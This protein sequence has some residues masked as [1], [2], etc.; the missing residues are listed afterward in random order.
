MSAAPSG[1]IRWTGAVGLGLR[2][3][4]AE[5]SKRL[6]NL[7]HWTANTVGLQRSQLLQLLWKARDTEIGREAGFAKLTERADEDL[8]KAYRDAVPVRE[9]Y[10]FQDQLTRMREQGEANVLWPGLVRHFAQTS[11]TT[12][13]DK[14][15]PIT[16]EMFASNR[17][18]A[19]DIFAHLARKDAG[20][21][22]S[23]T[24]LM[25]GKMLFLGGSSAVETNEHGVHTGD[26]SG[27]VTPLITWPLSEIYAPGKDVA[28]IGD[29]P[30]KIERMAEVCID[31]DVRSISGMPSWANVLFQRVIELASE[32][33]RDASKVTDVWPHLSL[34]VHGGVKYTPFIPRVNQLVHGDEAVDF[35]HRLELYP[36]SEGFIALQDTANDP[37]LRLLTDIGNFYEFIPVD[38]VDNDDPP[39][40]TAW[41]VEP[42]VRYVVCMTTCSG[43]WRYLIG[44]VVEF[45]TIPAPAPDA[46]RSHHGPCRLRI[47]GRHRHFIN[48]FG[49]NVIVEHV[50]NAVARAARATGVRVG[51]FTAAPVYPRQ[52]QR[53]GLELAVEVEHGTERLDGFAK[54]FDEAMKA[55]NVDYTTK[56]TDSLGMAP[57][58]ITPLPVGAFHAWMAST[59]KLGGQHK[60]P[61]CANHRDILDAVVA[62]AH[63][64]DPTLGSSPTRST[65]STPKPTPA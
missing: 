50:E 3:K 29:W 22:L 45:D 17:L 60:C 15:I 57:P 34:F 27:L 62:Q 9:W 16:R 54:A 18:A 38:E 52:G 13:G 41:Q 63:A 53:A 56:R 7:K 10:G 5:R 25:S 51:E 44:D 31:Q 28:L 46:V 23:L 4:N 58:T 8:L 42:G 55:Q 65:S 43:L 14:F 39:T 1:P 19:F 33:G 12:A 48:A 30:T 2:L 47:V 64:A 20:W 24:R 37:G 35:A 21:G 49:E 6:S 11:G 36:A 59:G 32:R 40:F 61:R 26:L